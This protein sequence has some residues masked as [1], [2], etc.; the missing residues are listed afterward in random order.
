MALSSSS[1]SLVEAEGEELGIVGEAIAASIEDEVS[2]LSKE[3]DTISPLSG[4]EHSTEDLMSSI[5][6]TW[7]VS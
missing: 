6:K 1:S 7:M 2:V 5:L 4:A 3:D